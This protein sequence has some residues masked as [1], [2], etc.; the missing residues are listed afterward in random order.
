MCQCTAL[1]YAVVLGLVVLRTKQ[2]VVAQGVVEYPWVL[3]GVGYLACAQRM[4]DR[5]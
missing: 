1:D 5:N 3:G 2:N 4:E